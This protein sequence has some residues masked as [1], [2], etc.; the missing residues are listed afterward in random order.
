MHIVIHYQAILV[1]LTPPNNQKKQSHN[2]RVSGI[3]TK[4][5][6]GC[7]FDLHNLR[8]ALGHLASV[9][10][11][12][13]KALS[14]KGLVPS[15]LAWAGCHYMCITTLNLLKKTDTL[16]LKIIWKLAQ[17]LKK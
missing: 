12:K 5:S 13:W 3:N 9:Q 1:R 16:K 14:E 8:N 2:V 15:Q 11:I 7:G 4:L 10:S 6:D 17:Q